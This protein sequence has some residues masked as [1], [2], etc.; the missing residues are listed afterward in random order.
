MTKH[1]LAAAVLLALTA[2]ACERGGESDHP[3]ARLLVAETPRGYEPTEG[4]SGPMDL[5][6][7][8]TSTSVST[9]TMRRHLSRAGFQEGYSRVWTSG[10]DYVAVLVFDFI[11]AQ[12]AQDLVDL[13]ERE[14]GKLR[15]S[16][17][18]SV[19]RV[20]GAKGFT[21]NATKPRTN[22]P[23]FC[24]IVWLARDTKAYEVRTCDTQPGSP[25]RAMALAGEQERKARSAS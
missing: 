14:I 17:A 20:E 1:L 3:L 6:L 4:A 13:Q 15:N 11:S 18:F 12:R 2:S 9:A 7:A 16:Q 22:D 23:I 10:K 8:A 5:D 21:L 19:P 25:D 24:Q